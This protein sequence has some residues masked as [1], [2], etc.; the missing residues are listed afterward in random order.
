[1][2]KQI[3]QIVC[4]FSEVREPYLK[5]LKEIAILFSVCFMG[6]AVSAALPFPIPASI[7]SMVFLFCLLATKVIKE[8]QIQKVSD[9]FL[10]NMTLFFIP[11]SVG[12]IKNIPLLKGSMVPLLAVC[13]ISTIATF[14]AA[15]GASNLV[16]CLI[17]KRREKNHE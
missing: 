10:N 12:I 6:L 16:S 13:I 5:I 9:F 7:V 8:K 17:E 1:M 11:V 14:S 15:Y 3:A 4:E 2:I